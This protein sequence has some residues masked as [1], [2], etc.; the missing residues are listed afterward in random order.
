MKNRRAAWCAVLIW[1]ATATALVAQDPTGAIEGT[2]TDPSGAVIASARVTVRQLDTGLTRET[3]SASNGQYRVVGLPVGPYSVVVEA[4]KLATA[5]REPIGVSVNQTVRLNVELGLSAVAERVTVTG[6][7]QL[8]DSATTALG[9]VVT[10]RELVDLPLNGRNFTQLGL[11]QTGVAPLTAGVAT[12]GGSLRQG[13]SYAVNGMRPEQN[14]YL[15][16]GAQNINRMDG[17][18][19]L[20]IPVDVVAEFRILTQGAPAEFGGTAGATTSIVTRSGTNRLSG[21]LYEFVRNDAFD[22]RN[23]FSQ[24]VEPLK[25]HQFGTTLGGPLR[26]DRTF[27]FGYYEGFRNTQGI[28]TS[29]TVP[30]QAERD[31]DFSGMAGP[32]LNIAAGGVPFQGNRLPPGAINPVAR[33]VLAMYPLGNVS[34]SIY[35][36]TLIAQNEYDQAGARIDLALSNRDQLFARYSYSGGNNNNPVSVRGSDAPGFPTRDDFGTHSLTV[37]GT[38]ILSPSLTNTV[39]ANYLRHKFFFDQRLNRTP[40]SALGFGYEPVHEIGQGPPFFNISGYTPIGGAITG[41]RNTTQDTFELQDSVTWARGA[42]LFKFGGEYLRTNIDMFQ[43]IAPN[44]FFVFSST[45][46]TNHVVANVLLGAPVVFYQ[47]FGDFSRE[48]LAQGTGLYA[49]DEWRVADTVT[50]NV[51]LRYERINPLTEAED[52][53]NGF[54]PGVQSVVRPDAPRGLLF[55]GDPGVGEGIAHSANAFMPRMGAAWDPAGDGTWVIRSSY[56][57]FYDQF[58]NGA[59]TASQIAISAIPAAQFVQFSGAGLN[60]Q[61]PYAN[62]PP[63]LPNSFVRPSTVFAMDVNNKPPYFHHWNAGVQRALFDRYVVEARYVGAAGR[64]LPRNVEANPAVYGPGATAQNADRR[65]IYANCPADG[66]PCDFSTVAMITNIA[67][68]SYQALQ[69]SVSRRYSTGVGFNVSYWYSRTSDHL[70]AMNLSGAAAKPLAGENDLAQNPFDLEAE[71]GPS[72]F[73]ARHRFVASGSWILPTPSAAAPLVRALLGGWQ[74][75]A[76]GTVTSGTPFTVSDSANVALQANSP[77]ISGFAASRP[78]VIGDPNSGPH[79]VDAWMSR[80]AFERLNIQTQAGQFGNAGRNIVRG[81]GYGNLDVSLVRDIALPH[82][83]R[84]QLRAEVF[85]VTNHVN[86]GLPVA[87]LNSP[88]FGRIFSAGPPRLLQ[89]G[90]KLIF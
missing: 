20:K 49:Q 18:Y 16:D 86:F 8:V 87:D 55:P 82:G 66:S 48:V 24:Q 35:R 11:L 62:R 63:I 47:G 50:L 28:T 72:L 32:L 59:G 90:A 9:R 30:T 22:A 4:P 76:I 2:V 73:D 37:S 83:T 54:V 27:F 53:L 75:N 78:N 3:T 36:E 5:V 14:L 41:P 29:A 46:P 80:S 25:Q 13:Q 23:F 52:R 68:A 44:A 64:R 57:L 42:H 17:G 65:R 88:N 39:R 15:L 89:F 67:R 34:P 77:P 19:A 61:N 10:G 1:M 45:F 12:A 31:G 38:R 7:G 43:G 56:G 81:P 85:N 40:P 6:S 74:F 84:L 26:R 60:F 33:N 79:T 58:Q 70:S 69:T 51:G 21:S 71:W